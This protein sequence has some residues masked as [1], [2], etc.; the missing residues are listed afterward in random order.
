[1]SKQKQA[2][3][4]GATPAKLAL[5]ALLAVVLIVVIVRQLPN[6]T[7]PPSRAQVTASVPSK[8]EDETDTVAAQATDPETTTQQQN[9][10][11]SPWPETSLDELLTHDPFATPAWAIAAVSDSD[12]R[13]ASKL[14]ELQKQGVSIVMIGEEAKTATIGERRVRVGDVLEGYRITDITSKGVLLDKLDSQ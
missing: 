4:V 1:M 5:V 10:T 12:T 2:D 7:P 14:D 9:E 11:T 6:D 3:R 13:Q 8:A